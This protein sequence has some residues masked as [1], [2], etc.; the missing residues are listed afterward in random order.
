[1]MNGSET[2][3]LDTLHKEL[4]AI[5]SDLAELFGN[6][7]SHGAIYGL[8]FASQKPLSM[9]EISRRL[10]ISMGSA[11]QGLRHLEE[12]D[13][14]FREKENGGRSHL[15]VA[16]LELKPLLAGF[17]SKRLVP[18]LT[19]GENRL[20]KLLDL[21]PGLPPESQPGARLRLQRISKW[22]KRASLLLPVA[23]K[24]LQTE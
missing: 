22:H 17:V 12:F 21:V 5:F 1:M 3:A 11:S 24:L 18:G 9:D 23:K 6:P 19:G 20:K 2:S 8:L 13:A 15:Y 14:V 16:R 4:V 10:D 7:R